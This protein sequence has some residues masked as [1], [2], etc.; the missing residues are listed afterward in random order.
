[1]KINIAYAPDDNFTNLTL[2]S[3]ASTLE[4]NANCEVEFIILYSNL[5]KKSIEA[6]DIFKKYK[7]CKIR[8]AK[9]DEKIFK[10]FS[11][12]SWVTVQSWFRIALAE[13]CP[14]LDRVLYLDCD[15]LILGDLS[16]LFSTDLSGNIIAGVTDVVGESS[17]V[18]R[19]DIADNKY[20]NSGAILFDTKKMREENT[21]EK[22]KSY[23]T[24]RKLQ[25]PDQDAINKVTEN[26]KL[27]L[28][29]KYN[30]LESW[31][32]GYKTDYEKDYLKLYE[33]AKANPAIIHFVG[34]KPFY[35]K[36]LHSFKYEWWKYAQKLDL[37]E[38]KNNFLKEEEQFKQDIK[39]FNKFRNF[40]DF[41]LSKIIFSKKL[42]NKFK[43]K[44]KRANDVLI[45]EKYIEFN[46]KIKQLF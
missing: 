28:H 1:M 16:E 39:H 23:S 45:S 35:Y 11:L 14:D 8:F 13:L 20:F 32:I 18:K 6:F 7:N 4:N 38:L 34:L 37:E 17:H 41:V 19:L 40:I 30:Y 24:G 31:E 44:V 36:S 27:L 12:A 22:I 10:Q 5:S 3:M 9:V 2:V 43:A 29:P 21:F 15:T 26:Q 33:E 46:E 25:C 42:R